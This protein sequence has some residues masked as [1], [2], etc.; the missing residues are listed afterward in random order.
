MNTNPL[1][2]VVTASDPA[3][4]TVASAS[5]T[6]ALAQGAAI[7]IPVDNRWAVSLLAAFILLIGWRQSHRPT[8][9]RRSRM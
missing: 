7:G 1:T 8:M 4:V 3:S 9:R 5:D 2:N 6:N